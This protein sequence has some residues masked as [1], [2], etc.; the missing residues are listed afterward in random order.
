MFN[1]D[2]LLNGIWDELITYCRNGM[3]VMLKSLVSTMNQT[4]MFYQREKK[5]TKADSFQ[6][7]LL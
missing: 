3:A 7:G 4:F 1:D 5:T 2:I 6:H